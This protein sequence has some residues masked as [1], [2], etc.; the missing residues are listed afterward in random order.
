MCNYSKAM[1]YEKRKKETQVVW[2][3]R[4]HT[5]IRLRGCWTP[6]EADEIQIGTNWQTDRWVCGCLSVRRDEKPPG[7]T[8]S[9]SKRSRGK[10]QSVLFSF[11]SCRTT[12]SGARAH[13]TWN[14][15]HQHFEMASKKLRLNRNRHHSSTHRLLLLQPPPPP[16]NGARALDFNASS[17]CSRGVDGAPPGRSVMAT[18]L[19]T[20]RVEEEEKKRNTFS[21]SAPLR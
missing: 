10:R 9:E 8:I 19:W 15:N 14:K 1:M 2:F 13:S 17:W 21:L 6:G 16:P 7:I 20:P 11:L 5:V 18:I 3:L 12:R 4:F